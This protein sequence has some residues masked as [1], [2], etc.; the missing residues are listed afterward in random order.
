MNGS[1]KRWSGSGRQDKVEYVT[2]STP[3]E[4]ALRRFRGSPTILIDGHDR[5][6]LTPIRSGCRVGSTKPKQA[7]STLRRSLNW[8]G[9]WPVPSRTTRPGEVVSMAAVA[10]A[11]ILLAALRWRQHRACRDDVAGVDDQER[12][13]SAGAS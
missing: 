5:S 1:A 8:K 12:S 2:V 10:M 7:P 13:S 11:V 9:R 6:P 3:E 4:A